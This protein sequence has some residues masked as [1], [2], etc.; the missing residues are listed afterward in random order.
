MPHNF[1]NCERRY[2]KRIVDKECL[3]NC[4]DGTEETKLK[5]N[6]LFFTS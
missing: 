6:R 2:G 3:L 1:G 5:A 4:G